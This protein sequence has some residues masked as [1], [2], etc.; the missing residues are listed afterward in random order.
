MY[1][2]EKGLSLS[3]FGTMDR[4]VLETIHSR[5]IRW[6]ELSFSH[7]DYMDRFDLPHR[8]AEWKA[9][10]NGAGLQVWSIHLPFSERWDVS[11]PAFEDT[12]TTDIRLMQAAGQMGAQ[13]AV[14]HPSYEPIPAEERAERFHRARAGICRLSGA[15]AALGMK[16]G[17]ENLPRTCLGNTSEELCRLLAGTGAGFLFDTNHSLEEDN[18]HF[19]RTMIGAGYCPVSVH[20]SDYDFVDE[21]HE[22]PGCGVNRWRELLDMLQAAGYAGP[23]LY[24]IRHIVNAQRVISFAEMADNMDRLLSGEIR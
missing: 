7:E 20:L 17:V 13:V 1:A 5:G 24:E 19:L 12:V 23:A 22:L 2:W 9:M 15:A 8:A 4:D 6:V 11:A 10:I 16:L 18:L 3:F 14:V 21:R